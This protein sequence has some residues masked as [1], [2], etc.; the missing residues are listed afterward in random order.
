MN[1][2]KLQNCLNKKSEEEENPAS[3]KARQILERQ[4][5]ARALL[6]KAK[7]SEDNETLTLADLVSILASHGNGVTPLNVW[8]INFYWFNNQFNRMKMFE[9]YDINIRS[10]LAGAK[11]E[12]V[13]LKH[14]MSKIK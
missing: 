3:E 11:S 14:W 6:A 8:D 2:I 13:D 1:I 7:G 4:K 5:R 12:D 9:E 10:L